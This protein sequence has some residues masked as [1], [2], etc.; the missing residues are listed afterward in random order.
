MD[1]LVVAANASD[2]SMFDDF[3][4]AASNKVVSVVCLIELV[5]EQVTYRFTDALLAFYKR[6]VHF[7]SAVSIVP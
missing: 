4:V 6:G 3:A 2:R 1:E 7:P 5:Q